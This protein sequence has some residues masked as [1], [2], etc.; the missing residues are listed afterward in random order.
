M[1]V[2]DRSESEDFVAMAAHELRGP[3]T[4]MAA[5]ADTILSLVEPGAVGPHVLELLTMVARS[6]R[7]LRKL[8]IDILSSAYLERGDLPLVIAR[9][10]LLPMIGW[11][12]EAT[13]CDV[14]AVHVDCDP[15][16][17]ADVDPD[18]F[19]RIVT[20]LVANALLHGAPPVVVTVRERTHTS[21]VTVSVRDAGAGV[22]EGPAARLFDR[23]S[24]LSARTS[25]SSGLGLSISRGLARAMGGDLTYRMVTPG[26]LF[27]LTL[28]GG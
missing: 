11:A 7:Q 21:G 26:S 10:P 16:V 15:H 2:V 1:S 3:A 6:G 22:A 9:V 18:Q 20:N 23:F 13:G 14:A 12:I 25:T 27:V 4:V 28:P 19:E 17:N 8:T 5:A 24:P